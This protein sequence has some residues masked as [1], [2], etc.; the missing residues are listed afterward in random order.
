[1]FLFSELFIIVLGTVYPIMDNQLYSNLPSNSIQD[2]M[3]VQEHFT[4]SLSNHPGICCIIDVCVMH[5]L[6]IVELQVGVHHSKEPNFLMKIVSLQQ[7]ISRT[8]LSYGIQH[9]QSVSRI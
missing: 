6:E 9:L 8:Q 2:A 4:A 5:Y 1:M 3:S 7:L